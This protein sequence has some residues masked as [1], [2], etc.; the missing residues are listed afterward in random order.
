MRGWNVSGRLSSGSGESSWRARARVV[1]PGKWPAA[2]AG[3]NGGGVSRRARLAG[4]ALV[5]AVAVACGGVQAPP[6]AAEHPATADALLEAMDARMEAVQRLR[7]RAVVEYYGEGGRAR[8]RQ[9]IVA[10]RPDRLRAETLSPFD[11]PLSVLVANERELILYDVGAERFFAGPPTAANVARVVPIRLAP[12]ELVRVLLG[13]AP[14]AP[15]TAGAGEVVPT[16]DG[17]RGGWS[18]T[19]PLADGTRLAL[20]VAHGE[21]TLRHAALFSSEGEAVWELRVGDVREVASS[22]GAA[23]LGVP[24]RLRFL[25]PGSAVDLS[26]ALE[27]VELNPALPEFVFEL[28]PPRGVSVEPL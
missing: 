6:P 8:V 19:L 27:R 26:L 18:F 15:G 4:L 28:D 16:W 10:E 1:V 12:P 3:P 7:I 13:G 14:V 17:R 20:V 23:R 21:A 9:V 22:D 24:E 25:M 2:G 5:A 11:A